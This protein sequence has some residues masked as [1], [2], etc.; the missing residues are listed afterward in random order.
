MSTITTILD[1]MMNEPAFADAVFANVEKALAEYDLSADDIAKFKE[2]SRADFEVFAS[3][4]PE[5]RKS[6]ASGG[7]GVVNDH[8]VLWGDYVYYG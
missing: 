7:T 8:N 3:A 2:I 6:L 4:S 5:E 1:R